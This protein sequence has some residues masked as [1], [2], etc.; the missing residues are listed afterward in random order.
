MKS[1]VIAAVI[2]AF[3]T[4][5]TALDITGPTHKEGLRCEVVAKVLK[6]EPGDIPAPPSPHTSAGWNWNTGGSW[7]K[8]KGDK[9][10]VQVIRAGRNYHYVDFFRRTNKM[11]ECHSVHQDGQILELASN[12]RDTGIKAG[13]TQRFAFVKM[14]PFS[15][16]YDDECLLIKSVTPDLEDPGKPLDYEWNKKNYTCEGC[17]E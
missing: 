15:P 6:T 9:I 8:C 2:S 7:N 5:A 16:D 12:R 1:L 10:T 14:L 11:K 13:D 4:G 3:S 17:F